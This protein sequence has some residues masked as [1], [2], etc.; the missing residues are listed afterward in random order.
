MAGAGLAGGYL[1]SVV[2][3]FYYLYPVLAGVTLPYAS[4]LSRMWFH[5]WI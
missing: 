2:A 3:N 4:W 1:L 5:G